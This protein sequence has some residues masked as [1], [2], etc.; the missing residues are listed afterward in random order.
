MANTKIDL[1]TLKLAVMD[2]N[3]YAHTDPDI[4]INR[5]SVTFSRGALDCLNYPAYV[6]FLIDPE[7]HVFAVRVCKGN[8]AKASAF[9]KPRGEQTS[10]VCSNVRAVHDAV[11]HLI[12]S[13][14]ET[15]RYRVR[16]QYFPEEKTL[17]FPMNDAEIKMFLHDKK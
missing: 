14:D 16:G 3:M 12:P 5:G 13:Y 6:Q 1:S 4:F 9:S 10:T 2:F 11:A 7:K 15:K 8:E 17:C